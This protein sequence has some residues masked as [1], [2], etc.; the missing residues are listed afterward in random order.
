MNFRV[1]LKRKLQK[2]VVL[3]YLIADYKYK[4]FG[5]GIKVPAV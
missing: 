5:A 3:F 1:G 4:A 2:A